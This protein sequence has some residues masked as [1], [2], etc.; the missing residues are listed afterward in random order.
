MHVDAEA[1][2]QGSGEQAASRRGTDQ[3]EGCKVNLYAAGRRAFVYHDVDAVVLHGRVEVFL[4]D[5]R[6]AVY[7]ID[8]EHIVWL[9]RG[10][11]ACQVAGLVEHGA[12]RELEAY[13]QLVGDDVGEGCLAQ[14]GRAVQEGVVEG[15]AAILGSLHEDAQVI[16]DLLLT[17]EVVELQRT[18]GILE[19]LL[20]LPS[21]L[22]YVEFFHSKFQLLGARG[23]GRG[24]R[25]LF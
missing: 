20:L 13:A 8:E 21:F 25:G 6:E 23:K 18:E 16:D 1:G 10:E 12:A 19:V 5:G 15:F 24:A 9:E 22:S 3:R 17:A 4:H 14:S 11:D 2:T 7:L